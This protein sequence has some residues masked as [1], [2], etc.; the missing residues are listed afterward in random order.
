M[1]TYLTTADDLA[2]TASNHNMYYSLASIHILW[3]YQTYSAKSNV[4]KVALSTFPQSKFL[5][6]WFGFSVYSASWH[7]RVRACSCS[8]WDYW[9]VSTTTSLSN[10]SIVIALVIYIYIYMYQCTFIRMSMVVFLCADIPCALA[11]SKS[12]ETF[13]LLVWNWLSSFS[14]NF[15]HSTILLSS[16]ASRVLFS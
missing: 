1:L 15:F 7:I 16:S 10:V 8:F 12:D 14:S 5:P 3:I 13:R 9:G 11:S 6:A 4:P 2:E